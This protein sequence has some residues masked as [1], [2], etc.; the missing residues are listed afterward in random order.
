[1]TKCEDIQKIMQ[2]TLDRTVTDAERADLEQHMTRCPDCATEF[3]SLQLSLD[4]LVAMP[5]PEPGP[6]FTSETIKRAFRAK[7]DNMR[8]QKVMSW[9][10][11]GLIAIISALIV[12]SWLIVFQPAI[13]WGLLIILRTLSG[14]I[15]LYNGLS[16]ALS[17][18]VSAFTYLGDLAVDVVWGVSSPAL[19][20]YLIALILMVFFSTI[21]GLKSSTLSLKRR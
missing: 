5:V 19:S 4:L 18:L 2:K 6:E 16:K 11:S 3:K 7:K 10:L 21:A 13:K 14:W 20:G 17:A 1:M 8:R 15:S 12:G 9:S